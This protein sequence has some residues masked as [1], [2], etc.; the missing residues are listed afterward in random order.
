MGWKCPTPPAWQG[1][2]CRAAVQPEDLDGGSD[3]QAE[4]ASIAYQALEI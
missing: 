4:F 2:L 3:L 1:L